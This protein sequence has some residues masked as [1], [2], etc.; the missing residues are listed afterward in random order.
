MDIKVIIVATQ[1]LFTFY[2]R[3]FSITTTTKNE[4]IDS[5]EH[6]KFHIGAVAVV[7]VFLSFLA[8]SSILLLAFFV[9]KNIQFVDPMRM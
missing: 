6:I 1:N 9:P 4:S 5:L 8:N 7:V 2:I 3:F